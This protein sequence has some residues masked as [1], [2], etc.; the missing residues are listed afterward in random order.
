MARIRRYGFRNQTLI[1]DFVGTIADH[2]FSIFP[3]LGYNVM[4]AK[5]KSDGWKIVM[6]YFQN[7]VDI[8]RWGLRYTKIDVL[9]SNLGCLA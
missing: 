3:R 1:H 5:N 6:K 4:E 2:V 8:C 7:V 9:A